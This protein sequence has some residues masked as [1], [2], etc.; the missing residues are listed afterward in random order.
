MVEIQKDYGGLRLR[1]WFLTWNNYPLDHADLMAAAKTRWFF[2]G[3]ETA[4][5]TGTQ[6]LQGA[7]YFANAT[8]QSAIRGKLPGIYVEPAKGT[9]QQIIDYCSKDGDVYESGVRPVSDSERG[10][11]EVA[12]WDLARD[13]AK[14]G[15]FEDIPSDIFIRNY[16]TLKAIAR[17]YMQP[18]APLGYLPGIWLHGKSGCGKTR[19]VHDQFSELYSKPRNNWWDGYQHEAV[20]LVDDL[21]CFDVKLGGQVKHWADRYPFIGECKGS[22]VRI[23]PARLIVTS[24]YSIE[25]IWFDEPT[26][27]AMR[28]R[29]K[30]I[31]M[32]EGDE[33]DLTFE[34]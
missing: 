8:T 11:M 22:S 17:D 18:K 20:V 21:D 32:E 33:V 7:L 10:A 23:R 16:S 25:E 19:A 4:P 9:V 30:V 28:R 13:A 5:T 34:L 27:E 3:K 15:R 1:F 14:A 12:R 31:K 24:Q 2:Y 6:H 29:F 26:R